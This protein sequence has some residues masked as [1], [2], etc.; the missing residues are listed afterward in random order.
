MFYSH[1]NLL[2]TVRKERLQLGLTR[3]TICPEDCVHLEVPCG[4]SADVIRSFFFAP[5][6][7]YMIECATYRGI[8]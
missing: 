2:I 6:I 3:S 8:G 1:H 5:S 7:R 4:R